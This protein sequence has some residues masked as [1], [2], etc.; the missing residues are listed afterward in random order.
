MSITQRERQIASVLR[1][2]SSAP[3]TRAQALR[4]AQLLGMHWTTVYRLRRRFLRDPMTTSLVPNK[5]GR[6]K[7]PQRLEASL[8]DIMTDVIQ[9]WLSR[10]SELA[11]PVLDSHTEI[12]RRCSKVGI[13]PPSRN[14]VSRRLKAHRDAELAR[15]AGDPSAQNHDPSA[16]QILRTCVPLS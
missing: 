16:R 10:Q 11:H 9:R 12:R 2:L 13:T 6:L 1:P 5:A 3:R 15:I 8:E 7:E 4:A 14:T